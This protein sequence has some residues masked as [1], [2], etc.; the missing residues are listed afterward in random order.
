MDTGIVL[1]KVDRDHID[2]IADR[3]TRLPGVVR[4]HE[5]AGVY[6][7]I[8]DIQATTREG[9]EN[10]AERHMRGVDGVLEL[11]LLATARSFTRRDVDSLYVGGLGP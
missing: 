3:L 9:L 1:M 5:V 7:L 2:R 4:A 8:A 11:E 6:D 10:L